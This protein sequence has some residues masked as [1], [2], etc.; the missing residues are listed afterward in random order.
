MPNEPI[1]GILTP[2]VGLLVHSK[3]C[4]VVK[5]SKE[6]LFNMAWANANDNSSKSFIARLKLTI[7]N[8]IGIYAD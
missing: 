4:N 8:K 1:V 7:L 5:I 3:G 2:R 6:S